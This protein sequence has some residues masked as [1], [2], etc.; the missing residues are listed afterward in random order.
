MILLNT[1]LDTVQLVTMEEEL[2]SQ[3][4]L[5]PINSTFLLQEHM[6]EVILNTKTQKLPKT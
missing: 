3:V 4:I 5:D 6:M 2:L 1:V